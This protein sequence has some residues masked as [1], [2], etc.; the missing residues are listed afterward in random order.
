MINLG[1]AA[2]G[3][4]DADA[5]ALAAAEFMWIAVQVLGTETDQFRATHH[6]IHFR[7]PRRAA[8]KCAPA[9]Q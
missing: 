6:P 5:L 9:V 7:S 4:R 1:L 8:K 3:A 2:R